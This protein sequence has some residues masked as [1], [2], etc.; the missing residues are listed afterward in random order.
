MMLMLSGYMKCFDIYQ[1]VA[2]EGGRPIH[3]FLEQTFFFNFRID[4]WI[5]M[6]LPIPRFL[7]PSKKWS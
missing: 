5:I 4:N 1:H 7:G 3:F 6:E 2:S